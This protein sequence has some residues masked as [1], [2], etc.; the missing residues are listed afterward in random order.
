M[1]YPYKSSK[2]IEVFE[3]PFN[4]HKRRV[5]MLE[6]SDDRLI[7]LTTAQDL[8]NVVVRAIEYDGEWPVI[9]GIKGT[10]M[11]VR[12][13]ISLGEKI[14]GSLPLTLRFRLSTFS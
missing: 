14:R 13:L 10:D 4:F 9:G 6:G 11:S 2:Y 8:A 3:T 12:Q 5:L 1:V 7:T